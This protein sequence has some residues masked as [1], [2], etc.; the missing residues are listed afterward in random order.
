MSVLLNCINMNISLLRVD[1]ALF[2]CTKI[3]SSLRAMRGCTILHPGNR[4]ILSLQYVIFVHGVIMP[5]YC[6]QAVWIKCGKLLR[7]FFFLCETFYVLLCLQTK[8]DLWQQ[9]DN[10]ERQ[11][12]TL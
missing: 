7:A 12:R 8:I 3:V 1:A 2:G 4:K 11:R 6:S 5:S 10:P 9:L